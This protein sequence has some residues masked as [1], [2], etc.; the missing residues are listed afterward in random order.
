MSRRTREEA[1]TAVATREESEREKL[2]RQLADIKAEN[3]DPE[4]IKHFMDTF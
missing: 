1:A 3:T 2:N 4:R